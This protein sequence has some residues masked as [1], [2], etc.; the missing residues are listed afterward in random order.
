VLINPL[1]ENVFGSLDVGYSEFSDAPLITNFDPVNSALM[2][3][4]LQWSLAF[5]CCTVDEPGGAMVGSGMAV[6]SKPPHN[7]DP[8]RELPT[9][10]HGIDERR[11]IERNEPDS[12][13]DRDDQIPTHE[14][15]NFS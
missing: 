2:R 1:V 6:I 5:A 4:L 8:V 13:D 15:I 14:Q 11:S 7:V 12:S 10:G 9:N 3:L